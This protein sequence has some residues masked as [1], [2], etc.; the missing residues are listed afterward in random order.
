MEDGAAHPYLWEIFKSKNKSY[1][2]A[3]K[4]VNDINIFIAS[5]K[6]FVCVN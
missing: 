4:N 3:A 2:N 5:Y 6:V 1:G